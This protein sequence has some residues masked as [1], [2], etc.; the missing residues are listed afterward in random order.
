MGFPGG[1]S[2]GLWCRP[3]RVVKVLLGSGYCIIYIYILAGSECE[4]TVAL[5]MGSEFDELLVEDNESP[6]RAQGRRRHVFVPP[7]VTARQ[8]PIQM[9][10]EERLLTEREVEA[11]QRNLEPHET[12][13]IDVGA[14]EVH[15]SFTGSSRVTEEAI[16]SLHASEVWF[17]PWL[18]NASMRCMMPA[19]F[20]ASVAK[21]NAKCKCKA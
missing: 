16:L 5:N 14:R 20:Q 2:V 13:R 21:E 4:I 3:S 7:A 1:S 15:S 18:Q 11:Y 9:T 8:K 17:A 6:M 10:L 12:E 19:V